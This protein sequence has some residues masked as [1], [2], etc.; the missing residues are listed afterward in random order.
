M[1]TMQVDV[2]L[3]RPASQGSGSDRVRQNTPPKINNRIDQATMKRVW[4]YARKS[5]EEITSRMKELD[6][7]RDLER[8]RETGVTGTTVNGAVVSGLRSLVSLMLPPS[9]CRKLVE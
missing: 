9:V 8:V 7:E 5:P 3:E 6:S 1:E 2:L 4:E